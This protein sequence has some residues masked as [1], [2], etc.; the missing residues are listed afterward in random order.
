MGSTRGVLLG[1]DLKQLG[2]GLRHL[3]VGLHRLWLGLDSVV[4]LSR[5]LHFDLNLGRVLHL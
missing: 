5:H 3:D 1:L 2:F 4:L